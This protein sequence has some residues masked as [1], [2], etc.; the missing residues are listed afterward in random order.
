MHGKWHLSG[1]V[2][3]GVKSD[4]A[5]APSRHLDGQSMAFV[6]KGWKLND[7]VPG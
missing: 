3:E 7:A 4:F 2:M 6:L 1:C 5:S